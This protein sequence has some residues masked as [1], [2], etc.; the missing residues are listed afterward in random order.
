MHGKV[1]DVEKGSR[2]AGAKVCMWK[3]REQD[4]DNQIFWE[5][6]YGNIRSKLNNMVLDTTG[7]SLL[8]LT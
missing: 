7:K 6:K 8:D 4:N 3:K 2:N 1:V 5:D